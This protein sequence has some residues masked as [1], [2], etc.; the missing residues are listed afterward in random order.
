MIQYTYTEKNLQTMK[1]GTVADA[2]VNSDVAN[3]ELIDKLMELRDRLMLSNVEWAKLTRTPQHPLGVSYQ[4][5][6]RMDLLANIPR[7]S[8]LRRLKD[9]L[10][11]EAEKEGIDLD[12]FF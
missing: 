10:I 12:G 9:A 1:G 8:N 4:T 11:R 7:R 6:R 5:I 3:I 2:P